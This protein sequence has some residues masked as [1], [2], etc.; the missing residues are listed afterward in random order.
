M[1]IQDKTGDM[2]GYVGEWHTHPT[3]GYQLSPRD[4]ETVE[5]IQRNL[6]RV[7]LPT[8]IMIVTRRGVYPYVF[9]PI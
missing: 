6:D 9:S 3:G 1:E 7:P 8:H 5:K 4:L 2:L